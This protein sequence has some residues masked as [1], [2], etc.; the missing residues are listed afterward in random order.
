MARTIY[1]VSPDSG[2]WKVTKGGIVQSRHD[3]KEAAVTAAKTSAKANT[4]SQVMIQ[5]ADGTFQEEV[6]YGDDPFPPRG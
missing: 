2:R 6:T 3:T 5:K 1:Y 4:P